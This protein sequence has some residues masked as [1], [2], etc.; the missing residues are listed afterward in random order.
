MTLVIQ[1][2]TCQ[3][4][5]TY[6]FQFTIQHSNLPLPDTHGCYACSIKPNL[7]FSAKGLIMITLFLKKGKQFLYIDLIV[8]ATSTSANQTPLFINQ[9]KQPQSL[10]NN[11][12]KLH[13]LLS[14][15]SPPP[16]GLAWSSNQLIW[17]GI[18]PPA[19]T[20]TVFVRLFSLWG[21]TDLL[22]L[23][24][25]TCPVLLL[26]SLMVASGFIWVIT[27]QS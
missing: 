27:V 3:I 20:A 8:W 26:T 21:G 24:M 17:A 10:N 13:N 16:T 2:Y 9:I 25:E 14:L 6:T 11:N 4:R 5:Q 12:N 18:W 1:T 23:R 7:R 22:M 19:W 15:A